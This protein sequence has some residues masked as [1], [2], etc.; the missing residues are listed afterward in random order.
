MEAKGSEDYFTHPLLT[1]NVES[2]KCAK[3]I[4][5]ITTHEHFNDSAATIIIESLVK[6]LLTHLKI[7]RFHFYV[8]IFGHT[9]RNKDCVAFW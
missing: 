1:T 8:I 6:S 9:Y 7:L 3:R 4:P 5:R 2:R